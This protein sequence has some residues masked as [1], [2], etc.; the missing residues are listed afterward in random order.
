M[1][2]PEH[3]IVQPWQPYREKSKME[4]EKSEHIVPLH[5]SSVK[6]VHLYLAFTAAWIQLKHT[7]M[8]LVS[9]WLHYHQA[10]QSGP[11]GTDVSGISSM[12]VTWTNTG[13]S[14]PVLRGYD[15]T[16]GKQSFTYVSPKETIQQ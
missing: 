13:V 4:T 5:F 16:V 8:G 2:V 12:T 11:E 14:M 7:S 10:F 1:N 15:M 9:S 3:D 6:C